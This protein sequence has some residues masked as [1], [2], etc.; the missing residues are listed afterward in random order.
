MKKYMASFFAVTALFLSLS[1]GARSWDGIRNNTMLG[2]Q[3]NLKGENPQ[4]IVPRGQII[5]TSYHGHSGEF[6]VKPTFGDWFMPDFDALDRQVA[7]GRNANP[8]KKPVVYIGTGY[9]GGWDFRIAWEDNN[10]FNANK[11]F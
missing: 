5:Q 7:Q 6:A 11:A 1:I 9:M 10:Q 3:I 4:P 2:V 8:G